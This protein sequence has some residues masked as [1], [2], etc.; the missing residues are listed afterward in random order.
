MNITILGSCRQDSLYYLNEYRI[1]NIKERLSYTHYTKEILQVIDYCKNGNISP[2]ET[3]E[4]FR[5]PILQKKPIYFDEIKDEYNNTQLFIIEISSKTKY[6]YKEKYVH[7]ILYS[8]GEYN[9]LDRQNV[10]FEITNDE[11]IIQDV[12]KMKEELNGRLIIVGHIVTYNE[13][14]RYELLKLLEKICIEHNIIFINPVKEIEKEGY[15]INDL[16]L[17]ETVISHYN[18]KGHAVIQKIYKKFIKN[19][20]M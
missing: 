2:E 20:N 18:N 9:V 3:I 10:H 13:G 16:I 19:F 8:L 4:C 7:H 6:K 1:T 5:T 12:L 15:N 14:S 17:N 11:E